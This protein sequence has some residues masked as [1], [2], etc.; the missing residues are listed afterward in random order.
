ML[1]EAEKAVA[2]DPADGAARLAR[3]I[4]CCG[5]GTDAAYQAALLRE[6]AESP[7]D[8]ILLAALKRLRGQ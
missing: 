2:D 3:A 1:A 6:L 4:A 8:P 7:G 5:Q